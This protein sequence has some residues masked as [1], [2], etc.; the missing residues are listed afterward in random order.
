MTIINMVG[1]GGMSVNDILSDMTLNY[2][3]TT[4][5]HIRGNSYTTGYSSSNSNRARR[6]DGDGYASVD[7]SSDSDH[8]MRLY[9]TPGKTL[10]TTAY[11]KGLVTGA[12]IFDKPELVNITIPDNA[13]SGVIRGVLGLTYR[14]G[15]YAYGYTVFPD[16]MQP[17]EVPFSK[18]NGNFVL[19][20]SNITSL[21]SAALGNYIN[22]AYSETTCYAA[23]I[24]KEIDYTTG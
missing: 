20:Y 17:Y 22:G 7:I 24:I 3:T 8:Y 11:R 19:D 10:T 21:T 16:Y 1:G 2:S 9:S 12:T 14:S 5:P 23:I 15:T 18:E 4:I 6:T 13:I